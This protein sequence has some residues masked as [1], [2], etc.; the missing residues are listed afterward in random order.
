MMG[1]SQGVQEVSD[2]SAEDSDEQTSIENHQE[3]KPKDLRIHLS[4]LLSP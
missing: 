4:T 1:D 2:F 3:E